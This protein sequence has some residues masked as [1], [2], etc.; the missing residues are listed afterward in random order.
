[1]SFMNK[2]G[3]ALNKGLGQMIK[4]HDKKESND[5]V[6]PKGVHIIGEENIFLEKQIDKESLGSENSGLIEKSH[7]SMFDET[8]SESAKNQPQVVKKSSMQEILGVPNK[9][10]ENTS[11][12]ITDKDFMKGFIL[13]NNEKIMKS[14]KCYIRISGETIPCKVL[15]TIYRVYIL[16]LGYIISIH[17]HILFF[18][19]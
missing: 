18:Y 5:S 15:L 16:L 19:I 8:K 2:V 12:K 6:K 14:E 4:T 11:N 1:M 10:K 7:S 9:K 13:I 3:S 17:L